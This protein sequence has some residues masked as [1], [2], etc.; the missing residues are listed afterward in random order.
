M[1]YKICQAIFSTNRI[2][3]LTR[4]LIAQKNLDFTGCEVD[5]I[6]ID[7]FPKDRNNVMIA[8]LAKT[9]GYNELI[10]HQVNQGLSVT[11]AE[12]WDLIQTRNYDYVWNQEDDVE[13]VES[14][15]ILDL[16]ELLQADPSISQVTLKRQPWY[17]HETE[18]VALA[19]DG[20]FK[21]FRYEKG[22]VLFSPI[23]SLYPIDRAKFNYNQWYQNSYPE[24]PGLHTAK[25]NEGYIGK[26]LAENFGMVNALIKNQQGSNLINHIG[27]WFVGQRVLKT[28]PGY[29]QFARYDPET[30]YYSTTG[31]LY[32]K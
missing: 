27:E 17:F 2:E 28:D 32:D 31:D 29:E 18:S 15:K 21:N 1:T 12:F 7:D 25:Y 3:Y 26:A 5:R 13:I 22:G 4:T 30:R 23:A 8:A 6:F 11:W 16:I 19:S 20:I 9:F 14:V 24:E 10:L